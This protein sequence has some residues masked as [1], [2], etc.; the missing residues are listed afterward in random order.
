MEETMSASLRVGLWVF[1]FSV[2]VMGKPME[3]VLRLKEKIP[4]EQLAATV[5]DPQS[6]RYNNFFTPAEIRDLV[7]PSETEYENLKSELIKDGFEITHESFTRL[8]ITV[9]GDSSLFEHVFSTHLESDFDARPGMVATRQLGSYFVPQ[10][11]NIIDS[12]TGF[13]NTRR[14][15]S[16]LVTSSSANQ[17][18]STPDDIKNAYGV[19]ALQKEGYLGTGQHIAIATYDDLDLTDVQG[20]YKSIGMTTMPS[21]DKVIFNGT[22]QANVDSAA[23][24]ETDAELSGMIAPGASIHVFPSSHNDDAGELQVFSAILDDNRAKVVN[25]SWGSCEAQVTPQHKADMDNVFARAVAQGVNIMVASGDSGENGCRDNQVNPDFP[26]AHPNV[27]AVGG[28]TF[29]V[30]A[31]GNLAET[32][33]SGSGGGVSTFYDLP[34][35]QSGF[36]APYIKRSFPD[37]AFNADP[38]TGENVWIH[39]S[40]STPEWIQIGGTSIAAPQWSGFLALVNQARGTKGPVGFINPLIYKL[41]DAQHKTFFD[42]VTVGN[43]GYAAGPGWDAVTGWGGMHGDL[44]LPYL[45]NQ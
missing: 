24:T 9:Q 2:T 12:V 4:M 26:G 42:D 14:S 41:T 38:Q 40:S 39:Y 16:H 28:T 17:V 18:A 22:P 20:Y 34:Q 27:V 19:T 32:G 33:W 23:E 36:V 8:L 13:D 44:L 3:V 15:Y 30:T 43:N 45:V 31:D 5:M 37:V 11:L 1:V 6:V 10:R 35:W 21:V 25:Y 7:A 29:A